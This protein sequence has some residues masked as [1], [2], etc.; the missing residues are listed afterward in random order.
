MF[1]IVEFHNDVDLDEARQLVIRTKP[2]DPRSDNL[3]HYT[4]LGR[5]PYQKLMRLSDW[6][7]WLTVFPRPRADQWEA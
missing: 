6:M 3:L 2:D 4:L 1:V 7:K 5:D